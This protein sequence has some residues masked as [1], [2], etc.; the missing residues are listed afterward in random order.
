M[1]D[2]AREVINREAGKAGFRGKINAK[3]CE[4]IYD[5]LAN[6]TW[7][8]QVEKCTSFSCPLYDVRPVSDSEKAIRAE[9]DA[10]DLEIAIKRL[11]EIT[12]ETKFISG[13]EVFK[14]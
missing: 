1:S 3:C 8:Q 9:E 14:D 5:P 4:C 2:L 10:Q 11:S 6:G 12:P 13:E 7:R